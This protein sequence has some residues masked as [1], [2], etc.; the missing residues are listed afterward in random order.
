[1]ACYLVNI[2]VLLLPFLPHCG[3]CKEATLE[4][5]LDVE[6]EVGTPVSL[7]CFGSDPSLS[8]Y[9]KNKLRWSHNTINGTVRHLTD[10]FSRGGHSLVSSVPMRD[11]RI[12][13]HTLNSVIDI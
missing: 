10:G 6:V 8:Y 1:M 3:Q 7:E 2:G 4:V 9:I 13:E 12:V 11:Q 5:G